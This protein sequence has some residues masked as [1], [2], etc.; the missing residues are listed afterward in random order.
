MDFLSGENQQEA[1]GHFVNG[2][3]QM[4]LNSIKM[5]INQRKRNKM[6]IFKDK[7][8]LI[9]GASGFIGMNL[10]A[11]LFGEGAR[12][13]C[14][15]RNVAKMERKLEYIRTTVAG[16]YPI[17][18][19]SL[20]TPGI[21]P[22][23]FDPDYIFL[24]AATAGGIHYLKQ[25]EADVLRT[26]LG[27]TVDNFKW[28][29]K[30]KNL[31]GVL[32][33]SSVCAYPQDVQTTTNAKSITLSEDLQNWNNPDSTYGWSKIIGEMFIK[34]F[35]QD[36]N[37]PGVSVRLFNVYGPHE[38]FDMERGHVIPALI[39]KAIKH[40]RVP[41][42]VFGDG[43]QVRSFLY[44]DDAIDGILKAITTIT[45][46]SIINI[47]SDSAY[48]IFEIARQIIRISEKNIQPHFTGDAVGAKGR[49][50]N[51]KKAK[52]LLQWKPTTNLYEG[53]KRTYAWAK[54]YSVH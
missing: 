28:I 36:Y 44:I 11:R 38:H 10:V 53:L 25:H 32:F 51:L 41:F 16:Y 37:V 24:L 54:K 15:T 12:I 19:L 42:K 45:D 29:E 20:N 4:N 23:I 52:Q 31:K 43:K 1:N 50:P 8:V 3:K 26:N 17:K 39:T 14:L 46:G 5:C 18:V 48:T 22:D 30:Y 33:M 34:H 47:G 13:T 40:P 35:T 6:S 27:L 49:R 7:Q 9:T 2:R 21:H